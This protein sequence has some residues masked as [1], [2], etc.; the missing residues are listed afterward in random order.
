MAV[1]E[2]ICTL[3][4]LG[5]TCYSMPIDKLLIEY[6]LVPSVILIILLLIVTNAFLKDI[7]IKLKGLLSITFYIIIVYSGWYGSVALLL[8]NFA[9]IF[10]GAGIVFFILTRIISPSKMKEIGKIGMA[11]GEK[12]YDVNLIYD[13]INKKKEE[14]KELE[15]MIKELDKKSEVKL[16]ETDKR[17]LNMIKF[18]VER[19]LKLLENQAK[20]GSQIIPGITPNAQTKMAEIMNEIHDTSYKLD[21]RIHELADEI[22]NIASRTRDKKVVDKAEKLEEEIEKLRK[23]FKKMEK[24]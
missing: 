19:E 8:Y 1:Q 23:D 6:L 7:N 24:K 21:S 16:T 3:F 18:E 14:I 4:K 9:V 11:F 12:R 2:I 22:K 17:V 10:L 5:A 15:D 13:R 20:R